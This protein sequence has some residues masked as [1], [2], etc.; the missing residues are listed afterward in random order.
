MIS[1]YSYTA[2]IQ[3]QVLLKERNFVFK[4]HCY[5]ML[6]KIIKELAKEWHFPPKCSQQSLL[7]MQKHFWEYIHM[8]RQCLYS[9]W[10]VLQLLSSVLPLILPQAKILK[11]FPAILLPAFSQVS[12]VK[13]LQSIKYDP[14]NYSH[15]GNLHQ[16]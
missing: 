13:F 6:E 2:K 10:P 14:E 8:A 7:K 5:L 12:I 15:L 11:H 9:T 4:I 3:V 16:R 1:T